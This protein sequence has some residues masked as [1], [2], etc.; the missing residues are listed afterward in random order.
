ME[1]RTWLRK[2]PKPWQ[3]AYLTDL[4][5][6]DR[7]SG[8]HTAFVTATQLGKAKLKRHHDDLLLLSKNWTKMLRYSE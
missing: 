5:N 2:A 1:S 7:L 6:T 4:Q 3:E 8:Y